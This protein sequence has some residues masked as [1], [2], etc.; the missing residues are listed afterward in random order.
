MIC[1]RRWCQLSSLQIHREYVPASWEHTPHP[2]RWPSSSWHVRCRWLHLW[3]HSRGTPWGP[4][5]SPHR[6][7]Q[8]SSW[9]LPS[10]PIAWWQA[11]WY[12]GCCPSTPSY[13]SWRPPCPNPCLLCHVRSCCW[14]VRNW[15]RDTEWAWIDRLWPP[16]TP[17]S[18][19][20]R[21]PGLTFVY[22][23]VW[24]FVCW[25]PI[26]LQRASAGS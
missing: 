20:L 25:G 13:A 26:Q 15:W 22:L 2:W 17:L 11:W 10:L 4:L 8:R 1:G 23:F 12:L 18:P 24:L 21:L 6:W 19:M 9:L 16:I 14:C 3:W 7:A 5:G